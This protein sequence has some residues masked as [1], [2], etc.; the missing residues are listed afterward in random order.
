M[1][2]RGGPPLVYSHLL[3]SR[4]AI[5]DDCPSNKGSPVA[6]VSVSPGFEKRSVSA[7]FRRIKPMATCKELATIDIGAAAAG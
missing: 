7:F 2:M 5:L 4:M 3:E 1:N 6:R